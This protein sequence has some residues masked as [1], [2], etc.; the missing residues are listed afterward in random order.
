MPSGSERGGRVV[1]E[2]PG[3]YRLFAM[4]LAT[5]TVISGYLS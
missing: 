3:G 5:L 1:G 4:L 2:E